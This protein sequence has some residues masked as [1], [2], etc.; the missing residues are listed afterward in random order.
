MLARSEHDA[1]ALARAV[2]AADALDSPPLSR[3]E[4]LGLLGRPADGHASVPLARGEACLLCFESS[5]R[6]R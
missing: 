2:F 6:V 3:A 1:M 4:F 5:A